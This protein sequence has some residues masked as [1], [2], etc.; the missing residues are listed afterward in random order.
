MNNYDV[1][2]K[3]HRFNQFFLLPVS[4][5]AVAV[6]MV[7]MIK[8]SG[9]LAVSKGSVFVAAYFLISSAILLTNV[10]T[11]IGF[12]KLSGYSYYS[13]LYFRLFIAVNSFFTISYVFDENFVMKIIDDSIQYS[14]ETFFISK[15][16]I[17]AQTIKV[18]NTLA[19]IGV[20][21]GIFISLLMVFYYMKRKFVFDFKENS[22]EKKKKNNHWDAAEKYKP[23]RG[24]RMSRKEEED[25][26]KQRLAFMSESDTPESDSHDDSPSIFDDIK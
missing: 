18:F 4:L 5:I 10:I 25:I 8:N 15:A 6:E 13:F 17:T 2:M 21:C 14:N 23:G 19:R 1:P 24:V 12:V 20:M 26:T 9:E 16:A 7:G 11:Q 22:I 3:F